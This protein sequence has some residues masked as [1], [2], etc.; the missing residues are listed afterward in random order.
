MLNIKLDFKE[1]K[2]LDNDLEASKRAIPTIVQAVMRDDFRR[3][4]SE[5]RPMLPSK[6][7]AMRRHFTFSVRRVVSGVRASLGFIA[8]TSQ[9]VAIASM[10]RQ[11]GGTVTPK[12]SAYL[13]IPLGANRQASGEPVVSPREVFADREEFV[14]TK[15]KRGNILA[16]RREGFIPLFVLKKMVRI[17]A[18]PIP[19]EDRVEANLPAMNKKIED[20]IAAAVIEGKK[21]ATEL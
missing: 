18:H 12:R 10:V 4:R 3:M 13:W 5:L 1:F 2:A 11:S 15:S 6:T 16:F 7:G 20:T 19:F 8:R 14:V 21:K 9:R 17:P